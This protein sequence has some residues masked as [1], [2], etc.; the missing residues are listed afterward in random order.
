VVG[1]AVITAPL[2]PSFYWYF[3]KN[4]RNFFFY[5]VFFF[6]FLKKKKTKVGQKLGKKVGS[7][8]SL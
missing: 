5:F 7:L 1:E 6:F 2:G 3:K 8:S 4:E